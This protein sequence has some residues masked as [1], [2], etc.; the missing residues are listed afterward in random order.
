MQE[1][2]SAKLMYKTPKGF[3]QFMTSDHG[4][5]SRLHSESSRLQGLSDLWKNIVRKFNIQCKQSIHTNIS[6]SNY[7]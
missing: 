2:A 7:S 6:V 1:L 5:R 3:S 4:A